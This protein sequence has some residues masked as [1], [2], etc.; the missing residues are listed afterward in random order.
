MLDNKAS[1]MYAAGIGRK[2]TLR[3]SKT[4]CVEQEGRKVGIVP[5]QAAVRSEPMGEIIMEKDQISESI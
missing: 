3:S 1:D 2:G 5:P 4:T